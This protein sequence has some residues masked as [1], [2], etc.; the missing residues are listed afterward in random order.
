MEIK[1]RFW[2]VEEKGKRHLFETEKEAI[3]KWKELTK[4][5]ETKLSQLTFTK[6]GIEYGQVSWEKIAL[7]LAKGE[8]Q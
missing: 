7:E 6:D 5:T 1:D 2:I 8:L 3:T 4:T